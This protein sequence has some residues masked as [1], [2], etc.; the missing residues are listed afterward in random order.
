MVAQEGGREAVTR[1][2]TCTYV[3]VAAVCAV[4]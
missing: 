4:D 1:R 3:F 2:A